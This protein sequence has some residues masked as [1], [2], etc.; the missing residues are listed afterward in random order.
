MKSRGS[1][2]E[3]L[4]AVVEP[5][6]NTSTRNE[7]RAWLKFPKVGG[8]CNNSDTKV[9]VSQPSKF[10]LSSDGGNSFFDQLG[11]VIREPTV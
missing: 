1:G 3:C 7:H 10:H 4:V 2:T 8:V 9:D 6:S 11:D 5:R